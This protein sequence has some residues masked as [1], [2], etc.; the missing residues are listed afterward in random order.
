MSELLASEHEQQDAVTSAPATAVVSFPSLRVCMHVLGQGRSDVRV[1]RAATALSA[2]G[3]QVSIVD[4]ESRA[5]PARE[6]LQG[7]AFRHVRLSP[8]FFSSRFKRYA[9]PRA[10]TIFIRSLWQVLKTDADCYHAHDVAALPAC[11]LAAR[12]H[13]KPLIFEAHEMPLEEHPLSSMSRGRR[14]LHHMLALLVRAMIPASDGVITVSPPIVEE[15]QRRYRLRRL[16]LVRNIPPYQKVART[17]RLHEALGLA[18]HVRIALYQGR[19]QANRSLDLLVRAARYLDPEIVIVLLGK[20]LGN[21]AEELEQLIAQERVGDRVKLLPAVPYQELLSWTASADLGLLIASPDYSLNVRMFLPNKLFEY[22]MAGV[23]VLTSALPAVVELV[24]TYRLGQV[25]NEL[26]PEAIAQA[27]NG[28]LS[29][30]EA[31]AALRRNA[32]QAAA[33]ELHWEKE[34]QSLLDLY[35][36]IFEETKKRSNP[37]RR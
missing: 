27:I 1:M 33:N 23:P 37:R 8:D 15:L 4:L 14:L 19:F 34:Q 13:R 16:A 20:G 35:Q 17:K 36:S 31:L 29:H 2:V 18:S 10:A 11:Y 28:M 24:E 32:L 21:A 12:L 26:K 22:I 7:I 30:P 6:D 3:C 5:Q 25:V 9:L